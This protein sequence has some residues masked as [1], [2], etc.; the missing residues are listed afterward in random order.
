[1]SQAP[2]SEG[3]PFAEIALALE[4]VG[5]LSGAVSMREGTDTIVTADD[6][7]A[8][9]GADEIT[10]SRAQQE[11]EKVREANSRAAKQLCVVESRK[12]QTKKSGQL[13]TDRGCEE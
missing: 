2:G 4:Q 3:W 10:R 5:G 6:M 13:A 1:M 12:A 8:V 9:E 11:L 7:Q